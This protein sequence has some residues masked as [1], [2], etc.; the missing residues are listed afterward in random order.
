MKLTIMNTTKIR[1]LVLEFFS[2]MI[3]LSL[4]V[5]VQ[6]FPNAYTG[7]FGDDTISSIDTAGGEV[8]AV[9]P[10]GK[11]PHGLALSGSDDL[12]VIDT[13]SG[14]VVKTIA[15]GRAPRKIVVQNRLTE[16]AN[17]II[18]MNNF[19]FSPP[20][21]LIYPGQTVVWNNND[22]VD[23]AVAFTEGATGS[24]TIS[25]GQSYSRKFEKPGDYDYFCPIHNYMTGKIVVM[26]KEK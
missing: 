12:S 9:I 10:V 20:L 13:G 8:A 4:P 3:L 6:A 14:K 2:A 16:P 23:H 19:A 5:I 26:E 1:L 7:N 24:Q 15:A 18:S 11:G 21:L 25:P 22:S 17:L